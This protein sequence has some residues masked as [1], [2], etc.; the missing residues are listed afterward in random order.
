MKR[1]IPWGE[2]NAEWAG[3]ALNGQDGLEMIRETQPDIVIT[4][5]YMPVMSG[6]DMIEHLRKDGFGGKII[7]LS[8]Y[9]DFEHARQ[10]LRFNVSD[11]VSKPISV[12]TLKSYNFV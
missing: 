1:V 2:L 10:A 6:L 5:I 11:Y 8:G 7:I 9:S 12:P 4:D 3:E